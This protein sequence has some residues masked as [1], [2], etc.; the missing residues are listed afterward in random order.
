MDDAMV[1]KADLPF[2]AICSGS[3]VICAIGFLLITMKVWENDRR[4]HS[5]GRL[6]GIDI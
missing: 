1:L 6:D 3:W 5:I 2:A 4:E